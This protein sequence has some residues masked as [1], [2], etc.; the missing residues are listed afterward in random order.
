MFIRLCV[1]CLHHR[2]EAVIKTTIMFAILNRSNSK[3][4][5]FTKS[6]RIMNLLIPQ[7]AQAND[8]DLHKLFATHDEAK[9]VIATFPSQI[10]AQCA[11]T[12]HILD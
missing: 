7:F 3:V 4:M 11:V 10:A 5:F 8:I 2:N 1:V 12:I 6:F 9:K